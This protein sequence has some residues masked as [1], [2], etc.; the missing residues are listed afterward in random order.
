MAQCSISPSEFK[1]LY[2]CYIFAVSTQSERLKPSTI[3][4]RIKTKF[5]ANVP[6]NTI[7]YATVISDRLLTF[8]SDGNKLNV[9][10]QQLKMT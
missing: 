2:P 3:D 8:K 5:R 10:Y 9:V 6:A 4:I 7:A 1:A